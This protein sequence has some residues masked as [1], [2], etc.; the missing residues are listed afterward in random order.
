MNY[1]TIVLYAVLKLLT[2]AY[3]TSRS[4]FPKSCLNVLISYAGLVMYSKHDIHTVYNK[5]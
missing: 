2:Q 1:F 4:V 3:P 5:Q